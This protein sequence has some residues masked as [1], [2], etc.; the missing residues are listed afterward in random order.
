MQKIG[1]KG[2]REPAGEKSTQC[3]GNA[4]N[5]FYKLHKI[6]T[7]RPSDTWRNLYDIRIDD[8]KMQTLVGLQKDRI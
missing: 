7:L 3:P 1:Y 8:F 5:C 2:N 6:L 4:H